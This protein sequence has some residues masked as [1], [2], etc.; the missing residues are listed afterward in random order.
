MK[1]ESELEQ[2]Q[3]LQR[4]KDI[5][6]H[7]IETV[8]ALIMVVDAS[9]RVTFINKEGT[10]IL[11]YEKEEIM[12]KDWLKHL[13]PE[14]RASD[15]YEVFKRLQKGELPSHYIRPFLRKDGTQ[16]IL[17][18]DMTILKDR[19]GHIARLLCVAQ[20]I[21][22]IKEIERRLRNLSYTDYLTGL[23]NTRYF[24][25][26]IE[27]EIQRSRRYKGPF[28]LLYI[29]IDNFKRCN[30]VHGHQTGDQVLQKFSKMLNSQLRKVD[31]A[32]R[33]GGEEF[34]VLLPQTGEREAREVTERIRKKIEQHLFPLYGI[35]VSIGV[36]QYRVGED[37]VKQADQAMY[38]A[39]RQGK[40]KVCAFSE[41]FHEE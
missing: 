10:R 24:Y 3:E 8:S 35:P 38:R 40:N 26:K 27:E 33:Y 37:I 2:I 41:H 13:A 31:F 36:A 34:V 28:S 12:G 5:L 16:R 20:D 22:Q 30:D 25:K 15:G 9:G 7:V 4:G 23:H 11:G 39:K 29:D 19:K 21:T 14:R 17:S 6:G 32:F 1:K 18:W